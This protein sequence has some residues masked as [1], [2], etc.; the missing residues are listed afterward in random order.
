MTRG[1]RLRGSRRLPTLVL[2]LGLFATVTSCARFDDAATTPFTP[3]PSFDGGAD[4]GPL[5]SDGELLAQFVAGRS[6][7]AFAELVR[8]HGRLVWTVCRHLTGSEAD[9]D[10]AFQAT[11]L[12]L[13]RKAPSVRPREKVANWLHGVALRTA[14]KTKAMTA[15]RRGREKQVAE[16]PEPEAVQQDPWRDLQPLLDQELN[17]LPENYRLPILLCDLEG[18][19]I[20]EA[21][22][23][24]RIT[25]P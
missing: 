15:R 19:T 12:V 7:A 21:A 5:E 1:A 16:M 4:I 23:G 25:Q 14:M 13:A 22:Q 20:K 24:N 2:A 18:K 8:R 11:F 9:A 17:G 6:E 10:D 3:E